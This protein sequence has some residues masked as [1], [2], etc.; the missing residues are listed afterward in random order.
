MVLEQ[1]NL[2][3]KKHFQEGYLL[4][5]LY[6]CGSLFWLVEW[7]LNHI[8]GLVIGAE[9][10]LFGEEKIGGGGGGWQGFPG[11]PLVSQD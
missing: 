11:G 3:A 4:Y 7:S 6:I 9:H 1:C 5:I 8:T 10:V 2:S